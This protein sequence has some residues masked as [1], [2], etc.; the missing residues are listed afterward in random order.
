MKN[1]KPGTARQIRARAK[2]TLEQMAERLRVLHGVVSDDP[3]FAELFKD[4]EN[5]SKGK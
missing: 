4:V 2:H 1:I 3:R 5:A